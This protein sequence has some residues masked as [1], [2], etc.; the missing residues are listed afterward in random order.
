MLKEDLIYDVGFHNGDDT[1]YYLHQGFNVLAI[2]ANPLL[3]AQGA[4]RFEREI[5]ARRLTILNVGIAKSEGTFSFWVNDENDVWSSF[6]RDLGCRHGSRCHEVKVRGVPLSSI[7]CEYGVPYFLKVDIEGNDA[8]CIRSLDRNELP[9]YI[10][11]ELTHDGDVLAE[12][13]KAGYRRFKILNQTTYTDSIPVFRHDIA[14][15]ILRRV[16]HMFPATRSLVHRV[17]HKLRP[18]K[19]EF[20]DFRR[21]FP[22]RF[23]DGSSGPFGE[24]TFGPWHS[25]ED[26]AE[27]IRRIRYAYLKANI[28]QEC[29]W[30]DVHATR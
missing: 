20:D 8:H 3:A 12:L 10:S 17:P 25:F 16:F 13:H 30:Y 22:Y 29:A 1:A 18:R 19:I 6:S 5:A 4:C 27:R 24:E 23:N 7:L 28:S 14:G 11:C 15:R 9:K 26:V 2:E 21:R